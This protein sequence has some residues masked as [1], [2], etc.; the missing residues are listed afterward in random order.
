MSEYRF[1]LSDVASIIDPLNA[2]AKAFLQYASGSDAAPKGALTSYGNLLYNQA[3]TRESLKH[4]DDAIIVSW[5]PMYHDVGLIG[6][7]LTGMYV[8]PI[9]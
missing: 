8:S 2:K 1:D 9:T 7:I 4:D 6:N 3:S 5:L